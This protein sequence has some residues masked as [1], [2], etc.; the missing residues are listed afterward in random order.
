ML[1]MK[2]DG[3]YMYLRGIVE[4]LLT[5]E[6]GQESRDYLVREYVEK[7]D[8]IRYRTFSILR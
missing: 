8:N 3:N 2:Q 5:I 6:H 7:D 1:V 4:I